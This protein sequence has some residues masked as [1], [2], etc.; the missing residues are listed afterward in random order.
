[1]LGL[2]YVRQLD[3]RIAGPVNRKISVNNYYVG[4]NTFVIIWGGGY[5]ISPL[6]KIHL[7]KKICGSLLD[8][9]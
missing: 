3:P 1:M 2:L 4:P 6:E 8:H 9:I 7:Y 5:W